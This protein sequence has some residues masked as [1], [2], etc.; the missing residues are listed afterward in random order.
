MQ[1][2]AIVR[3]LTLITAPS[4]HTEPIVVGSPAWFAWLHTATRF[5]LATPQGLLTVR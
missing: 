5:R 4:E 3:H 1:E 2:D